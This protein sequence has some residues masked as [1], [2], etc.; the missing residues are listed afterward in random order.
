MK[1]ACCVCGLVDGFD[2]SST[3]YL[4]CTVPCEAKAHIAG[5]LSIAVVGSCIC[6]HELV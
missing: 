6:Y 1:R 2:G 3:R 4:R 5:S